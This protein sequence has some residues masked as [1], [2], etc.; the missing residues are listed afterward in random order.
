MNIAQAKQIPLEDFLRHLGCTPAYQ[1]AGQFWYRSPFRNEETPSFKLNPTR[2]VWYDFGLGKGGDIIDLIRTKEQIH[3]VPDAL[4]RIR[5]IYSSAPAPARQFFP[6]A[7]IDEPAGL[8]LLRVQPVRSK[9]L[10]A[11][12]ESRG[13]PFSVATEHVVE[14]RYLR[15][16]KEYFALAFANEKGGYELRNPGFKGTL[17]SKAISVRMGTNTQS[18]AVFEGFIDYLTAKAMNLLPDDPTII[19]LNSVGLREQASE[20]IRELGAKRIE[21][22]P[23]NDPAGRELA[24]SLRQ[25]HP[26]VEIVDHS[27][28][29]A[30]HG[31]L[32]EYWVFQASEPAKRSGSGVSRS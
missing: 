19:V 22:F 32:N 1:K 8:E 26:D 13:I 7:S 25:S 14:A 3:N 30:T 29:Y 15:D 31:D 23:D 21:L 18:V 17:G 6:A 11:Y 2:N 27:A 20:H 4:D 5:Q 9:A 16:G 28:T 24:A 10:H 12:L